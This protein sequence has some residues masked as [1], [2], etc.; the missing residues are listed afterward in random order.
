MVEY[1]A[2]SNIDAYQLLIFPEGS[3]LSATNLAKSHKFSQDNKQR[4]LNNVLSP[5]GKM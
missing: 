4:V 2:A 5:R 1:G 3:D